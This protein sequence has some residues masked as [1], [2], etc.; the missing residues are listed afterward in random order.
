MAEALARR[1]GFEVSASPQPQDQDSVPTYHISE[2]ECDGVIRVDFDEAMKVPAAAW[3]FDYSLIFDV[4]VLSGVDASEI[5]GSFAFGYYENAPEKQATG[6]V[7]AEKKSSQ[8]TPKKTPD[9]KVA[10]GGT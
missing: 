7:S 9:G 10:S 3:S 1:Y 8:T 6:K 5:R 4:A 2:M